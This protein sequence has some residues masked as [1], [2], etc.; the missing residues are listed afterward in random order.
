MALALEHGEHPADG[1]RRMA[2]ECV[3]DATARLEVVRA[4]GTDA[5]T[6]GDAI[7]QARKRAKE[8]RALLRLAHHATGDSVFRDESRAVRDASRALSGA[9]DAQV[10]VSAF[11]DLLAA[12]ADY[13]PEGSY[14]AVRAGLVTR[15]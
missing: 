11:D 2:L 10:L 6:T 3:D 5:N 9:R 1:I 4:G 15:A 8:M 13:A 7:H 12:S 14:G